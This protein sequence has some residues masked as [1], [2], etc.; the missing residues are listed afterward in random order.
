[1][2]IRNNNNKSIN[3]SMVRKTVLTSVKNYDVNNMVFDITDQV[4]G[5]IKYIRIN[6][7]TKNPDGS[8]GDL[9]VKT[10]ELYS[11]GIQE[12]TD[13]NNV[14]VTGYSMCVFMH[15]RDGPTPEQTEWL[16]THERIVEHCKSFLVSGVNPENPSE[17]VRMRIKKPKLD[18]GALGNFCNCMYR[19]INDDGT[20][21]TTRGPIF[22]PK[23]LISKKNIKGGDPPQILCRFVD[24]DK[25]PLDPF[26]ILSRDK[27]G[28]PNRA[29]L[30][31]KYDSIYI[32][33][34]NITLQVKVREGLIRV[35]EVGILS[36]L[37]EDNDHEGSIDG[38]D[39]D[40]SFL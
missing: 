19:K 36:L 11:S 29:V 1:M 4:Y 33:G 18:M 24:Q 20:Y 6:I 37:I 35:M 34:P 30:A 12:N 27:K 39:D 31:I 3:K 32:G 8:F 26:T 23:L 10:P 13:M 5:T 15:E 40:K 2:S 21:D 25:K 22:Y 7:M 28:V 9:V 14:S 38:S 16:D 17:L